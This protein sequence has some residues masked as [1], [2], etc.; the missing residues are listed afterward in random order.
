M[1]NFVYIS[2]HFP[3]CFWKFCLA[4]KNKGF[5]VL[6]IGDCPYD[7]LQGELKYSLTEYYCC[8]DMD[9]FDNERKAVEYFQ[10]K[11]GH[12]DYLESNN[13]YWLEKDAEL[14]KIFNITTGAWPE[15]VKYY[16]HKSLQKRVFAS[17]GIKSARYTTNI[18]LDGLK[19]F[20]L[21][22]NYP[23]FAKP[24]NGVGAHGTFK[25][26]NEEDLIK[27]LNTKDKKEQYIVEEFVYGEIISYDGISNS[28]GDVLFSTSNVFL[29]S[30]ADIVNENL[31]DMYYCVPEIDKDFDEI[32]RK[33]VKE[34]KLKNRFF[35]IEFFKL[36]EDH[37]Y[38]GKKG[39]IVPL[40]ANMRPAG[41]YTPDLINYANSI[42]CYDIFAD[43]LAFDENRQVSIGGKFYAI[44]PSRRYSLEYEHSSEE[45]ISK[46]K[47]AICM[48]GVYPKIL[49]DAM[50]DYYFIA[51]FKTL[52]E[53]LEFESFVRKKKK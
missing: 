8:Y 20:V 5:N 52:S 31:D 10:K 35:H 44:T 1:K 13:E 40:E 7:H 22:V 25:I 51:K 38:L 43:S 37:P 34:F 6:G 23:I 47:D 50:G 49:R 12:I 4:L 14:R 53:A 36:L 29:T 16:K 15:E 17:A 26:N 3:D 39:T 18:T 2:P 33:I 32:G 24:D 46:Y 48:H 28:T 9:N 11:Y 42:S 21:K 30:V 27:F 45:I 19:E 41:G